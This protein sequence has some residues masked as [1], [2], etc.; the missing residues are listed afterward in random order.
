MASR[1]PFERNYAGTARKY[2]QDITKGRITACKWV[3]LAC[4]RHLDDLAKARKRGYPYR[5][6]PWHAGDVCDFIEKL[7]HVEGEWDYPT[8]ILEPWQIF[9]LASV[10][11]W[12]RKSDGRRR[13]N[14]VYIEL[15]RKNGKSVLS[16]GVALYCLCCEGEKGPQIKTAATTGDQAR[17]IFDVAKAMADITPELREAFDIETFANSVICNNNQGNIKPINAKASSQDG[18]NPHLSILDELHAH[19][20]R[21]LFDVL[22]SARGARKNPLSWYITTAGY[23]AE[24]VCWEQRT[25]VTKIL[26]GVFQG[27]HY[28]GVIYTLDIDDENPKKSDDPFKQKN[29]RKSNPNLGVS[30]QLEEMREY[31]KEA[32]FSPDSETE[33]KIKRVNIWVSAKS[34]WIPMEQWKLCNG[35]VDLR[36]AE[37]ADVVVGGLDLAA[38]SDINA[39]VVAWIKKEIL[40]LYC[41]F[42][43]PEMQLRIRSSKG[44][45]PYETWRKQGFLTVTPGNVANYAYIE[46][47][48]E[49]LYGRLN[50]K[51]I[52][53]DP[54][55]ASDLVNRLTEKDIEMIEFRQGIPSYNAPMKAFERHIKG[56]TLAH[57]GNPVLNWM[58]SNI[59]KREDVN[60]NIAPDRKK[61]QDKIDGIVSAIMALGRLM[62]YEDPGESIYE[63]TT[64]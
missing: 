14:T 6:D 10:F 47:D 39:F 33:F 13:F 2:A 7:P 24:G 41:K 5:F 46:K 50:I 15:A 29:W 56:L 35:K 31:A 49:S 22:K 43:V 17:I 4:Q 27:D 48:I 32:R 53:Y 62:A 60:E 51:E 57:G 26:E 20:S 3:V 1:L 8:L 45:I 63:T 44:D 64:I 61:S 52:A 23:N 19:E 42:Y 36:E 28:F 59:I 11:G 38:T 16:S 9:I 12:R 37:K 55:N 18:L 34:C 58:A 54:W 21:R 40:K 30:I 25:L